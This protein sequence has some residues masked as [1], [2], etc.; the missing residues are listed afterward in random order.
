MQHFK[1]V[2]R[3]IGELVVSFFFDVTN[4]LFIRKKNVPFVIIFVLSSTKDSSSLCLSPLL[5]FVCKLLH[6]ELI[7]N[8]VYKIGVAISAMHDPAMRCFLHER[9]CLKFEFVLVHLSL[10]RFTWLIH[11]LFLPSKWNLYPK[12]PFLA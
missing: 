2:N 8:Y 3:G 11:T 10:T 7:T 12:I 5:S 1:F 6:F 4:R 9:I